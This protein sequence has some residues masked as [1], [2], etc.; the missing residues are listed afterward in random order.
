MKSIKELK[1][2]YSGKDVYVLGAGPS[3]SHLNP[4]F[5]NGKITL[6][7]N[8]IYRLFPVTYSVFKH[9]QFIAEALGFKQVIIASMHDEGDTNAPI[10]E[11]PEECY[12]FTHK[13][14]RRG[15]L[16][17]N[18]QENL[19]AIGKDDDIFV[20]Y[21]T[22]TSGIHLAAYMGAK[23]I[24]LVGHDCGTLDGETCVKGYDAF[25]RLPVE[26]TREEYLASF[27][28]WLGLIGKET[29]RLKTRLK[30]VYGCEIYSLNP[31]V[32]FALEGHV[33]QDCSK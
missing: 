3:M 17:K 33:Y 18:F 6:G 7:M 10:T 31:F 5:F 20:S 2:K 9:K 24:I 23:T 32:N 29:T 12:V 15:D 22:I 28:I 30:E 8:N 11:G 21:S 27:K 4:T 25:R 26:I 19:N 16:E 1:N 13:Q 14:G